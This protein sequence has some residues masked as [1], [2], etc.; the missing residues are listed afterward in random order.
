MGVGAA[1]AVGA[2]LG[3][4]LNAREPALGAAPILASVLLGLTAL[5][6]YFF[7]GMALSLVKSD[8]VRDFFQ[9]AEPVT[10]EAEEELVIEMPADDEAVTA[11]E[12]LEGPTGG[13]LLAAAETAPAAPRPRGP[14]FDPELAA[15]EAALLARQQA[16]AATAPTE[17][18]GDSAAAAAA[19]EAIFAE[20]TAAREP[21]PRPAHHQVITPTEVIDLA[22]AEAELQAQPT[23]ATDPGASPERAV[24]KTITPTEVID[25]TAAESDEAGQ[26]AAELAA[27]EAS[28]ERAAL[29]TITPT[30]VIDLAEAEAARPPAQNEPTPAAAETVDESGVILGEPEEEPAAAAGEMAPVD[31]L[32]QIESSGQPTM[33]RPRDSDRQGAPVSTDQ[34][35]VIEEAEE[36]DPRT[37]EI[38]KRP[39]RD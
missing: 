17:V 24:L 16:E 11:A 19:L 14:A 5:L 37:G 29:E 20:E 26:L 10:A 36:V 15:M 7:G 27:L 9:A 35:E 6:P 13:D 28:A 3:L 8:E 32:T 30:E 33:I 23:A 22:A 34:P 38:I 4:M 25:L 39:H 18:M 31:P 21:S 12:A 2:I 1:V